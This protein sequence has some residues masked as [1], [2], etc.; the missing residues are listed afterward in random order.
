MLPVD[1]VQDGDVKVEKQEE[2]EGGAKE[3][4]MAEQ[5]G[6]ARSRK[7]VGVYVGR[8]GR[9]LTSEKVRKRLFLG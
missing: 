5:V 3:G 9:G 7:C 8:K 6:V 1:R 4:G 2:R